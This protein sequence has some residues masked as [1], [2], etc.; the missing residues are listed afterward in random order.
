MEVQFFL[1]ILWE[2]SHCL[3]LWESGHCLRIII[4]FNMVCLGYEQR[5]LLCKPGFRIYHFVL[6]QPS[7]VLSGSP[8]VIVSQTFLLMSPFFFS[9]CHI[10]R[11]FPLFLIKQYVTP[12]C[13]SVPI[14]SHS[15]LFNPP[16]TTF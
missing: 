9:P 5:I 4:S 16:P 3:A 12:L 13:L 7:L 2:S 15:L 11:F 14:L 10:I 1:R 6:P 8:L